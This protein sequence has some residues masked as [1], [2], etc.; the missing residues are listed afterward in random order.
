VKN[1]R[2]CWSL[3]LAVI[4]KSGAVDGLLSAYDD[5]MIQS[6]DAFFGEH[7]QA[8]R[9]PYIHECTELGFTVPK[10]RRRSVA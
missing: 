4:E 5:R 10:P 8:E 2:V 6:S 1:Y 9:D 3:A 7:V